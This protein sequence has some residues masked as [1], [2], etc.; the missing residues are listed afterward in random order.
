MT[1][2]PV[3]WIQKVQKELLVLWLYLKKRILVCL[4]L[5]RCVP[6]ARRKSLIPQAKKTR[7]KRAQVR[8]MK[9]MKVLM[10]RFRKHRMKVLM[11][12]LRK[13]RMKVLMMRL[14][15]QRMEFLMMSVTR[16]AV[17]ESQNY[18]MISE[19]Q[20]PLMLMRHSV[21]PRFLQ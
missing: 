6:K 3:G 15:K 1:C 8:R 4:V 19:G 13:Q 11:M 18:L 10:M 21:T 17:T 9:T 20:H 2:V 14:R 12:R 16:T 5:A 7:I